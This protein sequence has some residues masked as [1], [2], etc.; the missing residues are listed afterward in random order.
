MTKAKMK[1]NMSV[2]NRKVST[3][4]CTNQYLKELQT[5][6]VN[7]GDGHKWCSYDK[8]LTEIIKNCCDESIIRKALNL[9]TKYIECKAKWDMLTDVLVATDNFK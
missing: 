8:C 7:Y 1:E 9:Y 3:E 4:Y 2:V 5:L 6:C